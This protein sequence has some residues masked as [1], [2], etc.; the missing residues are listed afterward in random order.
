MNWGKGQK[1][2]LKSNHLSNVL[3]LSK[4]ESWGR[5]KKNMKI[6]DAL[7]VEYDVS[8]YQEQAVRWHRTCW[9]AASLIYRRKRVP[10][11]LTEVTSCSSSRLMKV[12]KCQGLYFTPSPKSISIRRSSGK[13]Q[14]VHTT[15]TST[16]RLR[17]SIKRFT[18]CL[19]TWNEAFTRLSVIRFRWLGAR[20][21]AVI[22]WLLSL[23]L[24]NSGHR[25]FPNP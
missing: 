5:E 7:T 15:S 11:Q 16:R 9:K 2:P 23:P 22:S 13:P 14:C 3:N 6:T 18:H 21:C 12:M 4:S 10:R 1:I 19:P 20:P 8:E 24:S 17:T 25:W